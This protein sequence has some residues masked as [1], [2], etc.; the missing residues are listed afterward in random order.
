MD[1]PCSRKRNGPPPCKRI[2][3]ISH[4]ALY[5]RSI[6][7]KNLLP[8]LL[9]VASERLTHYSPDGYYTYNEI[10]DVMDRIEQ[11]NKDRY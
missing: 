4:E 11:R 10:L 5:E 7:P 1:T 6:K 9:E 3:I 2:R 8:L